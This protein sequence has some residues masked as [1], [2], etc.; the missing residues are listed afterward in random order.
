M[1]NGFIFG[2]ITLASICSISPVLSKEQTAVIAPQSFTIPRTE[3]IK[4]NDGER[5]YELYIKLP[6]GYHKQQNKFRKYPVIYLTDAMYTFQVVSGATRYPMNINSIQQAIIVGISW[7]KGVKGDLSRVRDYT[8]SEDES[9]KKVTGGAE[10]HIRFIADKV[11]PFV[12]HNYRGD[13]VQRIYVGNSLGGLFGSY[14]LLHYPELFS[15]YVLGSPSFWWDKGL[16]LKSLM[17][18]S[19]RSALFDSRIF[20]GI[21]ELETN[22][23]EGESNFDMTGDARQ[24]IKLLT[25][26]MTHQ[27]Q[28]KLAVFDEANHQTAFPSTAIQGLY[29]LLKSKPK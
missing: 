15:G 19:K 14:I 25:P 11:I 21:G 26:L 13:A 8:I 5:P 2:L 18:V 28:L 22:I 20:I 4:I 29:W 12:E 10:R 1:K 27:S 9:W 3:I 17:S 7:E 16:I 6:R 24:F 23:G